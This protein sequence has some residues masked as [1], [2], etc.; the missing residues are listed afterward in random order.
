MDE[1]GGVGAGPD[2]PWGDAAGD[3]GGRAG[4]TLNKA[5]A[6]AVACDH[7]SKVI[8]F[9][10]RVILALALGF[11]VR[12][13]PRQRTP[14]ANH[15]LIV[16]DVFHSDTLSVVRTMAQWVR[17][18]RSVGRWALPTASVISIGAGGIAV[19]LT[20]AGATLLESAAPQHRM[21]TLATPHVLDNGMQEGRDFMAYD[22]KGRPVSFNKI[23]EAALKPAHL[24]PKVVFLGEYH[25]DPVAHALE[26]E[27]FKRAVHS[28]PSSGNSLALSLEMFERDVQRLPANGGVGTLAEAARHLCQCSTQVR[29]LSP[30]DTPLPGPPAPCSL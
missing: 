3:R 11:Y 10:V 13:P 19:G 20:P 12:T 29:D 18:V 14:A 4:A 7:E 5:T 9:L 26:L 24:K 30:P 8:D 22:N 6:K 25:D 21:H 15:S 17:Q 16:D 28:T 23:V 27:I 1:R 2:C